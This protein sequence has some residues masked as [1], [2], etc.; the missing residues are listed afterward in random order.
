MRARE[1]DP[2]KRKA[3]YLQAQKILLDEVPVAWL[4]ELN[5]PTLY[6]TKLSNIVSSGIGLNDSL[7]NASVG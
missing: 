1:T 2:E 6:R 5:F 3:I 4:L 7:G